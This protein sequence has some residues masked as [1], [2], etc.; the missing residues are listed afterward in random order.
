MNSRRLLAFAL[1]MSACCLSLSADAGVTLQRFS[2]STAATTRQHEVKP[3]AKS[4]NTPLR[5]RVVNGAVTTESM[6]V[7]ASIPSPG[8]IVVV[9]DAIFHCSF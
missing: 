9:P 3:R 1:V 4:A 2:V 6:L 8:L 7:S 5:L